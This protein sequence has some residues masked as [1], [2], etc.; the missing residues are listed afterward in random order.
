MGYLTNDA[1]L[2][3]LNL[4]GTPSAQYYSWKGE[5]EFYHDGA[6]EV[7]GDKR[8]RDKIRRLQDGGYGAYPIC[9]VKTQFSFTTDPKYRGAID[10][11]V[12]NVRDAYLANGAE[13]LVVLTGDVMT[14]PGLPRHP[15]AERIDI[16]A[17]G[18]IVGLI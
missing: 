18:Q 1:K 3:Y 2:Q 17:D 5:N 16:D 7:T 15:A 11:H 13:F 4:L 10:G 9:I 8:V 14:M 12:F 6:S